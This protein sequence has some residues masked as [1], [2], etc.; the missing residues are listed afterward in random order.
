MVIRISLRLLEVKADAVQRVGKQQPCLRYGEWTG[1]HSGLRPEHVFKGGNADS[2]S[3]MK[4][5]IANCLLVSPEDERYRETK[6]LGV[7]DLLLVLM[8]KIHAGWFSQGKKSQGDRGRLSTPRA[9]RTL[10]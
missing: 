4:L 1:H 2:V 3:P 10:W 6:S 9:I 5:A 7:A 8:G